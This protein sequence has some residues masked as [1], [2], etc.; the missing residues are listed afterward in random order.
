VTAVEEQIGWEKRTGR[1]AAAAAFLSIGLSV[2]SSIYVSSALDTDPAAGSA[3]ELLIARDA[4]PGVFTTGSVISGLSQL[5]LI[6]VLIY[7]YRA[8]KFRRPEISTAAFVLAIVGPVLLAIA[9]L[10]IQ[11]DL[12]DTAHE[13]VQSGA[14]TEARADDLVADRSAL[15]QSVGLSGALALAF[16]TIL[17]SQNAMRAGLL[18][19]FIGIL[20]IVVGAIYVI[21]ALFPLGTDLVQLFWLLALGLIFLDRWPGGR[22]E[23]WEKGEAI[24]WPSAAQRRMAELEAAGEEGENDSGATVPP[25]NDHAGEAGPSRTRSSRKRKKKQ[26]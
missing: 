4:Q 20:G 18:S 17:I 21:G 16:S 14:R 13:F 7:L 8:T 15:A 12:I 19:R 26:R 3:R 6:G 11:L 10:L 1:L 25:S 9:G 2:A 5:L 22:G 24:E 23:A